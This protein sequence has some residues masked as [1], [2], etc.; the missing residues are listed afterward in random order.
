MLKN[1]LLFTGS[2]EGI[3]AG[4]TISMLRAQSNEG[5]EKLLDYQRNQINHKILLIIRITFTECLPLGM[6]ISV[7]ECLSL[8]LGHCFQPNVTSRFRLLISSFSHSKC[9][10]NAIIAKGFINI[11]NVGNPCFNI[12]AYHHYFQGYQ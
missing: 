1:V 4:D 5:L 8:Q 11:I 3:A 2:D 10:A 6:L 12:I 7:S 9:K